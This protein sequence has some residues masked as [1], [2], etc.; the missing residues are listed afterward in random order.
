MLNPLLHNAAA[1][2]RERVGGRRQPLRDTV[3][4]AEEPALGIVDAGAAQG[5]R[6]IFGFDHFGDR[7]DLQFTA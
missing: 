2:G 6:D 1:A 3:Q 7:L 5:T 4:L